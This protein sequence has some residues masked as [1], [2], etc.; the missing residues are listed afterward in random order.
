MWFCIKHE[1]LF[2]LVTSFRAFDAM[3]YDAMCGNSLLIKPG[4]WDTVVQTTVLQ[5]LQVRLSLLRSPSIMAA[6]T[7]QKNVTSKNRSDSALQQVA[8]AV[9]PWCIYRF[10][11]V[12]WYF[13]WFWVFPLCVSETGSFQSCSPFYFVL[14][15]LF[16]STRL[17][18]KPSYI[19][20]FLLNVERNGFGFEE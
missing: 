13:D 5:P 3:Q 14:F 19:I 18:K 20:F 10:V 12:S 4:E 9:M 2:W 7:M 8:P 11:R 1:R 16:I 17:K 6:A 15:T